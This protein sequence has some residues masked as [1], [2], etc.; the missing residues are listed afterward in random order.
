MT[1]A[2]SRGYAAVRGGPPLRISARGLTDVGQR[3]EHNEDSLL[4]DEA[5]ALFVVADG[6]GGHA[7]GATASR[8]AV[9]TIQG[10]LAALEAASRP[11]SAR[12]AE[13]EENPLPDVLGRAVERACA[14]IF[15]AAQADPELTGH[16]DHRHRRAGRRPLRLRGPRRATAGPTS[17]APATS[18]R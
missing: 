10:E 16:G 5:L 3:R 17:C 2:G 12:S 13:G 4:V 14:V 9:E 11:C 7:G 1:L 18:T 8:L 6:M 15:E